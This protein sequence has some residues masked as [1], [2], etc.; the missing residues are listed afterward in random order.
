MHGFLSDM[1]TELDRAQH[2]ERFRKRIGSETMESLDRVSLEMTEAMRKD[3]RLEFR[4][5]AKGKIM[6]LNN[7]QKDKRYR[8]WSKS[9]HTRMRP[10]YVLLYM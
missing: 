4:Q 3:T 5:N 9:L 6:F 8:R 2:R 10:A 1:V 7:L